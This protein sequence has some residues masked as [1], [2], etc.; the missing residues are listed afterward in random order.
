VAKKL[1]AAAQ[2]QLVRQH[3]QEIRVQFLKGDSSGPTHMYGQDM[4]DLANLK[5]ANP[6]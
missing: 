3:H 4:P 5:A 6:G 2:V 1:D